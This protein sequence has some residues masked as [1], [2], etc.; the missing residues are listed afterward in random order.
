MRLLQAIW[1]ALHFA[2]IFMG[3]II[4]IHL[5]VWLGLAIMGVFSIKFVLMLPSVSENAKGGF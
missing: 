2:I 3:A 1:F 5:D 4:T